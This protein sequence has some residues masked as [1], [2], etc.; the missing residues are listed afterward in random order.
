M[1]QWPDYGISNVE[2]DPETSRIIRLAR[3]P[4]E[5]DGFGKG[6]I[7]TRA[8]VIAEIYYGMHSYCTLIAIGKG[9][10]RM[11]AGVKVIQADALR[12]LRTDNRT[13]PADYI[14]LRRSPN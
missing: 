5:D 4:F 1:Q 3:H 6:E 10:V 13:I 2:Y 8:T 7:V 11:G 9:Q 14:E 12:Y